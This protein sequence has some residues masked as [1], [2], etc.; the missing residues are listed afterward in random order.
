MAVLE[1]HIICEL[2]PQSTEEKKRE[3]RG[4]LPLQCRV[5]IVGHYRKIQNVTNKKRWEGGRGKKQP[6]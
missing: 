4:G 1:K 6:Y 3:K 2:R 5:N